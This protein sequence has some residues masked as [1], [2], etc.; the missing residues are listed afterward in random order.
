MC[1]NYGLLSGLTG[2]SI[3]AVYLIAYIGKNPFYFF[4]FIFNLIPFLWLGCV[5][6]LVGVGYAVE[7]KL[8]DIR[9][10]K[11][12]RAVGWSLIGVWLLFFGYIEALEYLV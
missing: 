12:I 5:S 9:G 3:I 2:I 11:R 1:G 7:H 6:G 10:G 8:G 4:D